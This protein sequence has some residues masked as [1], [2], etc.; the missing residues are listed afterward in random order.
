MIF[1]NGGCIETRKGHFSPEAEVQQVIRNG[2]TSVI[3]EWFLAWEVSKHIVY[4]VEVQCR[5]TLATGKSINVWL[6]LF[7]KNWARQMNWSPTTVDLEQTED[8]FTFPT[9]K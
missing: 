5:V 9:V 1:G 8:I 4:C 7:R 2:A 6:V 3:N